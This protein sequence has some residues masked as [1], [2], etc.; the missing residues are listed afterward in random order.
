[1]KTAFAALKRD[2][3]GPDGPRISTMRNHRFAILVYD[4]RKEFEVRQHTVALTEELRATGWVVHSVDL[5]KLLVRRLRALGSDLEQLVATEKLLAEVDREQGMTYLAS[6]LAPLIEGAEGIASDVIAEIQ[7]FMAENPGEADR[8][9]VLLGRA[10]VLYPY[11]RVSA[12]LRYLDGHVGSVPLVLL[13]PGERH[14]DR[15]LS[16]M[17]VLPPD[18]DYRPRIYS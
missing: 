2:L 6:K 5:N 1:M 15:G 7:R 10:G 11:F 17:G 12:L 4:P 14:G 16:F 9:L 8:T 3:G 18:G 13:Y